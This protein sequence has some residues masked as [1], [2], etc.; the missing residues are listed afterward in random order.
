MKRALLMAV[1]GG[2]VCGALACDSSGLGVGG[3]AAPDANDGGVGDDG[4]VTDAAAD[5][6]PPDDVGSTVFGLPLPAGVA[7]PVLLAADATLTGAG[8]TACSHQ[9]K[10]S[11]GGDRWCAFRRPGAAPGS[12]ELWV[13]DVSAAARGVVPSCDGSSTTCL[14]LTTALWPSY[15]N[16]FEGDTLIFYADAPATL[17][18]SDPYLGPVYAWRPGWTRA[19]RLASNASLCIGHR[20]APVGACLDDPTGDADNPDDVE[21]RVGVIADVS[22]ATLPALPGRW[23]FRNDGA[24]IWQIAFS[25][26]GETFAISL[27]DAAHVGQT[28]SV[29]ATRD[30]ATATLRD[31]VLEGI[32][33]WSFSNDGK[34]IYFYRGPRTDAT[35]TSADF[36]AG[37]GEQVLATKVV[38]HLPLGRAPSELALLLRTKDAQ[39][40]H[41]FRL[42]RDRDKPE[43]AVTV[44]E[45]KGG[46]EGFSIAPDLSHV[47]WIDNAFRGTAIRVSDLSSCAFNPDP[48]PSVGDVG[49]VD[50]ASFM[51]WGENRPGGLGARDGMLAAPGRCAERV[52]F[53]RT[54]G[55]VSPVGHRGLV[56]GDE[57]ED[58]TV[59][60]KYAGL[61][62]G[63]DEAS[64][65]GVRVHERAVT[66]V[67]L[68]GG[69]AAPED[70]RVVYRAEATAGRPAGVYM[71]APPF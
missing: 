27:P 3:D 1:L 25:P 62:S 10:A 71:F 8:R 14:R 70:V 28:L 16:D 17:K 52:L 18:T 68:V 69:V 56:Y 63:L 5:L 6:A 11:G 7:P 39:G 9:D 55:F 29:I 31:H 66:P 46:L 42:L 59:T 22:D 54:L 47:A 20:A 51:Y 15:G 53:A 58:F 4:P 24:V 36:P 45:T 35:L 41:A 49:F 21:L 48:A 19:R 61:A 43:T 32:N 33:Q 60:L 13:T 44:F 64:R 65:G 34:K 12:T 38:D 67:T 26:D 40:R 2:I 30:V 23:P 57:R 37:T 50:D